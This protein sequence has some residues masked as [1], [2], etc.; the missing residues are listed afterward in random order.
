MSFAHSV[1]SP[2]VRKVI[3]SPSRSTVKPNL[4][5]DI[6]PSRQT[7]GAL[8]GFFPQSLKASGRSF[9]NQNLFFFFLNF[10]KKKKEGQEAETT[11]EQNFLEMG[12]IE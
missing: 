1:N 3:A 9:E 12:R 11:Q 10:E 4:P 5:G 6:P 7:R 8:A 2:S